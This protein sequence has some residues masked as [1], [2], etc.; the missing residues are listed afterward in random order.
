VPRTA[1]NGRADRR[2]L[3]LSEQQPGY[4]E[5][6]ARCRRRFPAGGREAEKKQSEA[7]Y[8]LGKPQINCLKSGSISIHKP[9][10]EQKTKWPKYSFHSH[11]K[12]DFWH[13][14]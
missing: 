13:R 5:G 3:P 14:I 10:T 6:T 9:F 8:F 1:G 12:T 2:Q 7:T 11:P 4:R